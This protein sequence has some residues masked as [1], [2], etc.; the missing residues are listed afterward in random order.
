MSGVGENNNS[1][2]CIGDY[3]KTNR[4]VASNINI[5]LALTD[6]NAF[7]SPMGILSPNQLISCES[8]YVYILA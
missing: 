6:I 1:E 5:G 4:K 8:T 2:T 7:I 3:R